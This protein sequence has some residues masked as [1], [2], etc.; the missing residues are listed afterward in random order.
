MESQLRNN[1]FRD[2][3]RGITTAPIQMREPIQTEM[4]MPREWSL[5]DPST[6]TLEY[7]FSDVAEAKP[8]DEKNYFGDNR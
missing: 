1:A 5:Y 8:F 4:V 6:S 3:A 2:F 7:N